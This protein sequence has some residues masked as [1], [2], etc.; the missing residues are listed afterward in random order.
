MEEMLLPVVSAIVDREFRAGGN[1]FQGPDVSF[2]GVSVASD[3]NIGPLHEPIIYPAYPAIRVRGVGVDDDRSL[4]GSRQPH[5]VVQVR[6]D[7]CEILA[8]RVEPNLGTVW[9]P[10]FHDTCPCRDGFQG[11]DPPLSVWGEIRLAE[12]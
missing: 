6:P 8:R 11:Y 5:V 3:L 7:V 12:T 1:G 2:V 10:I 9:A 4:G